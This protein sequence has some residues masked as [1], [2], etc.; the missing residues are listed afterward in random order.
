MEIIKRFK[1]FLNIQ[2]VDF[3]KTKEIL[4]DYFEDIKDLGFE[5]NI[6]YNDNEIVRNFI[7]IYLELKPNTISI[8]DEFSKNLD[9]EIKNSLSHLSN[10]FKILKA[11]QYIRSIEG[12]SDNY[13]EGNK[14][15]SHFEDLYN[16][17]VE[18]RGNEDGKP[19][20]AIELR[21][22]IDISI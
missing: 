18:F 7:R 8:N 5:L 1:K 14:I 6:Y 19:L 13:V 22:I 20:T 4:I 10:D 15:E 11:T 9:I 21:M 12:G 17:L 16:A 3:N 2:D